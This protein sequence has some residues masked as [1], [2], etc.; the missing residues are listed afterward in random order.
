[1]FSNFIGAYT[2]VVTGGV[3]Q[4]YYTG[5][6]NPT[7]YLWTFYG[8]DPISSTEASPIVAYNNSGSFTVKLKVT[9]S[10]GNESTKIKSQYILVDENGG[11]SSIK[12]NNNLEFN[13]YPNPS[14][15]IIYLSQNQ[16]LVSEVLVSNIQGQELRRIEFKNETTRL[17]LSEFNKGIYFITIKNKLGYKTKVVTISK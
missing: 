15:G 14:N 10:E 1:L 8:A 13:V 5:S 7:E 9:D 16:N 6:D 11:S 4:Y 3:N 2:N 12:E 17:D